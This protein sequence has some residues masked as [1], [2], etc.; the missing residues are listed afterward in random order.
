MAFWFNG[1]YLKSYQ[2]AKL[3][4]TDNV[5]NSDYNQT[6]FSAHP[7]FNT[8]YFSFLSRNDLDVNSSCLDST[9]TMIVDPRFRL[10]KPVRESNFFNHFTCRRRFLTWKYRFID[11]RI[12][13]LQAGA[14]CFVEKF[15][16]ADWPL[17]PLLKERKKGDVMNVMKQ[18]P[19]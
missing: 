1:S 8:K 4:V 3:V 19:S 12:S 2:V 9:H 5:S 16:E 15:Q 14:L 6:T 17:R 7:I 11:D 13:D 10:C 18:L